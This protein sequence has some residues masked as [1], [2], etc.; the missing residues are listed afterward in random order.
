MTI[1]PSKPGDAA[2]DENTRNASASSAGRG[3]EGESAANAP[4]DGSESESDHDL[5]FDKQKAVRASIMDNMLLS[6]DQIHIAPQRLSDW[7]RDSRAHAGGPFS[8]Y[9]TNA[10]AT[11]RPNDGDQHQHQQQSLGL[12]FPHSHGKGRTGS[13]GSE[14]DYG[15]FIPSLSAYRTRDCL[16]TDPSRVSNSRD[17]SYPP[18]TPVNLPSPQR[19]PTPFPFDLIDSNPNPPVSPKLPDES[20]DKPEGSSSWLGRTLARKPSI[21]SVKSGYRHGQA[22]AAT[23]KETAGGATLGDSL[24]STLSVATPSSWRPRQGYNQNNRRFREGHSPPNLNLQ[25]IPQYVEEAA[26]PSPAISFNKNF[27]CSSPDE[28]DFFSLPYSPGSPLSSP[29][30]YEVGVTSP[31]CTT[32][33]MDGELSPASPEIDAANTTTT[34]REPSVHT[35]SKTL[36]CTLNSEPDAMRQLS[37]SSPRD[38]M[39]SRSENQ[40]QQQNQPLQKEKSGFFR[41]FF[42]GASSKSSTGTGARATPTPVQTRSTVSRHLT[43][44]SPSYS[45]PIWS[46]GFVSPPPRPKAERHGDQNTLAKIPS[47]FFKKRKKSLP[48]SPLPQNPTSPDWNA[49]PTPFESPALPEQSFSGRR[50]LQI[51]PATKTEPQR[52]QSQCTGMLATKQETNKTTETRAKSLW[53]DGAELHMPQTH[54]QDE[55]SSPIDLSDVTKADGVIAHI[56]DRASDSTTSF[57]KSMQNYLVGAE[58]KDLTEEMTRMRSLTTGSE[59]NLNIGFLDK[60]LNA[61]GAAS[62]NIKTSKNNHETNDENQADDSTHSPTSPQPIVERRWT[63]ELQPQPQQNEDQLPRRTSHGQLQVTTAPGSSMKMTS[64]GTTPATSSVA[65]TPSSSKGTSPRPSTEKARS[66]RSVKSHRSLLN[67]YMTSARAGLANFAGIEVPEEGSGKS[68]VSPSLKP[69]LYMPKVSPVGPCCYLQD[70]DR[71]SATSGFEG[72]MTETHGHQPPESMEPKQQP[73]R[74]SDFQESNRGTRRDYSEQQTSTPSLPSSDLQ[75]ANIAEDRA[76]A[77]RL[78]ETDDPYSIE[79]ITND[80]PVVA[81]LSAPSRANV[82]RAYMEH[83]NWTNLNIVNALRSL[84]SR[85][86]LKGEGQQVDR[87]LESFSF[88]WCECNPNHLFK[89]TDVVHTIS[90][91]LLLLNT[92]L[93][94]AENENKMTRGQFV[95]NTMPII[96]RQVF[97]QSFLDISRRSRGLSAPGSRS[98]SQAP[99][100]SQGR[101]VT[102]RSDTDSDGLHTVSTTPLTADS[103]STSHGLSVPGS[104]IH[105]HREHGHQSKVWDSQLESVLKEFYNMIQKHKL[106]LKGAETTKS[107]N[108]TGNA[109]NSSSLLSLGLRRSPSAMGRSCSDSM[110]RGSRGNDTASNRMGASNRWGGKSRSRPRLYPPVSMNNRTSIEDQGLWSPAFTSAV[111]GS[112]HSLGKMTLSSP[113]LES[114]DSDYPMSAMGSDYQQAVGFANALGNAIAKDD[115]FEGADTDDGE[116]SV[117]ENAGQLLDDDSLELAGAPWVKEGNVKHKHDLDD[118]GKRVK[119]RNWTQCFA[120]IQRGWLRLFSFDSSNT[121]ASKLRNKHDKH[122]KKGAGTIVVG[123][124]NWLESAE[125]VDAI[126]LRQTVATAFPTSGYS[127]ARPHVWAL[128]LPSGAIH[129]FQVG[130]DD[131]VRE[132]VFSANYWSARLSKEP[133]AGGISN[134]EYGW[135]QSVL[136]LVNQDHQL[137]MPQRANSAGANS[138]SSSKTKSGAGG[139]PN[140]H[141]SMR[142]SFDGSI[143][144]PYPPLPGDK[145]NIAEWTPPQQS[146]VSS[147]L[148]EKEQIRV[149]QNYMTSVIEELRHHND[150]RGP[151]S[152][153]FTYRSAQ[154]NRAMSNWE[155]KNTYLLNEHTKSKVYIGA[156]ID[157]QEA[158]ERVYSEREEY[159]KAMGRPTSSETEPSK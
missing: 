5:R 59:G 46:T 2:V 141:S 44:R 122:S 146:M 6:L 104:Q 130:T 32:R 135:S 19:R 128:T 151:M 52:K 53:N 127:K 107:A 70:S 123:G 139:R 117:Y 78:F 39:A 8:T 29:M 77:R 144:C 148:G 55:V 102:A 138:S 45:H 28:P 81:W 23:N 145:I 150:L 21:K 133:L 111:R 156:L 105:N 20:G 9:N 85:I 49:S 16:D 50:N 98:P 93:H 38:V 48:T 27:E 152:R 7:D 24:G 72:E 143:S 82:R 88:R 22:Q 101:S 147:A 120:V 84:C 14:W 87:V 157:A 80:E 31:P 26:A 134:M 106:P 96:Q 3:R 126:R 43:E 67:D 74:G 4:D 10:S 83:F 90:Y 154:Y 69:M 153:V 11:Q 37:Y 65:L 119:D 41:K 61:P 12:G 155:R 66:M 94:F 125:E 57:E 97:E 99:T 51:A 56:L 132:F 76:L 64:S 40:S 114:V 124:G 75:D 89:S 15:S 73:R 116:A 142:G 60:Q 58:T 108:H 54:G 140:F 121:K 62:S 115:G 36:Q 18:T 17:T 110:G 33:P 112:K 137:S 91:S 68:R 92:D 34:R 42:G 35:A 79:V 113:S 149:I 71:N 100:H 129:L 109:D 103:C 63:D 131:I 86:P 13:A 30:E 158:R 136:S 159:K 118:G 95:R 47:G 1:T 25:P